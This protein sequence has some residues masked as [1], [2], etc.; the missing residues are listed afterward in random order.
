[1]SDNI[2]LLINVL[3]IFVRMWGYVFVFDFAGK[4]KVFGITKQRQKGAHQA[5]RWAENG[6]HKS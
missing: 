1:M 4:S 5:A 2:F 6:A 3:E